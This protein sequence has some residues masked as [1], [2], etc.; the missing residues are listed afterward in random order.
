LWRAPVQAAAL[1]CLIAVAIAVFATRAIVDAANDGQRYV[2]YRSSELVAL[3]PAGYHN[4][5]LSAPHGTAIAGWA[6]PAHPV[7]AETVQAT[8]P[9]A[10]TPHER[11]LALS[12]TLRNEVGVARGYLGTVVFPGGLTAWELEYTL[13]KNV[14]AVFDFNA[15]HNTIAVTVSLSSTS[16]TT[17]DALSLVLP[18]SARPICEGSD[19]SNVDRADP[20]VPLSLPK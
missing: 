13:L 20:A 17:L 7:D 12:A 3:V 6:D 9:A 1:V 19:F 15:C 5:L 4:L 10:R 2:Y 18:Q 8:L 16:E 11:A 14:Y